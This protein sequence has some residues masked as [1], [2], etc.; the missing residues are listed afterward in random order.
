LNE[1]F[2]H[3][4]RGVDFVLKNRHVILAHDIGLGK[5]A[6]A[7]IAAERSGEK[8]VVVF[9]PAYLKFN[10]E[11][12]VKKWTPDLKTTIIPYSRL[13]GDC[14]KPDF[15]IADECHFIKNMRTNRT[16]V[17]HGYIQHYKPKYLVL[18]S[19]TPAKNRITELYSLFKI[20]SYSDAPNGHKLTSSYF[21]FCETFSNRVEKRFNGQ[22]VFTYE[23]YK[24]LDTLKKL[25]D[26][27]YQ[28]VKLEDAVSLPELVIKKVMAGE[29]DESKLKDAWDSF[30]NKNSADYFSTVKKN[31]ALNKAQFTVEYAKSLLEQDIYPLLIFT[32]HVDSLEYIA[33]NLQALKI[34]G[35]TPSDSRAVAFSLFQSGKSKVLVGT[36]GAMSTGVTL[37]ASS[38]IIFNDYPWC[39]ADLIQA[40]GRIHRVGQTKRCIAHYILAGKIDEHILDVLRKKRDEIRVIEKG[41]DGA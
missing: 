38:H 12:E 6:T 3:Q 1:L 20:V 35:S 13:K 32:D 23:G 40:E 9:C 34:S 16:Q 5:S 10:W 17:L 2:D 25:M 33:E 31:N 39:T 27:K 15:V 41:P 11:N 36:I 14:P 22:R 18:L 29:I 4:L 26:G 8:N 19:G 7:L 28:R 30:N 21:K 37:T 24:N